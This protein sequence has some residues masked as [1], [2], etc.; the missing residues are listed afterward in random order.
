MAPWTRIPAPPAAFR[1]LRRPAQDRGTR[2]L[3]AW[4]A[5]RGSAVPVPVHR[6][7]EFLFVHPGTPLDVEAPRHLIELPLPGNP[8]RGAAEALRF[9]PA[10]FGERV[11]RSPSRSPKRS[12]CVGGYRRLLAAVLPIV[13]ERRPAPV[14]RPEREGHA[15]SHL[16]EER[17]ARHFLRVAIRFSGLRQSCV[18]CISICDSGMRNIL[19][20]VCPITRYY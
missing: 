7:G 11:S 9:L 13:G 5:D 3:S 19:G 2:V 10:P 15:C 4:T 1:L 20:E 6:L 16:E 14:R 18:T 17:P 12:P 8:L